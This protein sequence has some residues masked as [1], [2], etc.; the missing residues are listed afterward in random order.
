MSEKSTTPPVSDAESS[1]LA[2][3]MTEPSSGSSRLRSVQ[4]LAINFTTIAI[5]L[6][7]LG[8]IWIVISPSLNLD[9]QTFTSLERKFSAWAFW[10]AFVLMSLKIMGGPSVFD[11]P[12]AAIAMTDTQQVASVKEAFTRSFDVRGLAGYASGAA[13]IY[14]L[15][16]LIV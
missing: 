4:L 7:I 9:L 8:T 3:R 11:E 14:L 2:E 6:L 15:F 12:T 1:E 5:F 13:A 16:A 10:I